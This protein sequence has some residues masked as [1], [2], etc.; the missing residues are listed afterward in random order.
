MIEREIDF[1]LNRLGS[2]AYGLAQN[3]PTSRPPSASPPRSTT[4]SEPQVQ[5]R[6]ISRPWS[7]RCRAKSTANIVSFLTEIEQ[8][9]VE[10]DPAR[11]FVIDERSGVVVIGRDVRVSTVAVAQGNLTVT[12]S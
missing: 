6:S 10:P 4:I 11:V 5:N 8:L 9:Q 2:A 12:V 7:S 1:T 3:N